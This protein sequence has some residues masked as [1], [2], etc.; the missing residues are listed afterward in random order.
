MLQVLYI[1]VIKVDRNV[2]HIVMTI[3][4]CF[5]CFICSRR[6]LQVFCLDVVKIDLDVAYTCMLQAVTPPVLRTYLTIV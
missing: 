6:M 1:G 4:V 5:R 2:T 3:H